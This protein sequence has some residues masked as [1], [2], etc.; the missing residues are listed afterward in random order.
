MRSRWL[1]SP[2]LWIGA[3]G[4]VFLLW[5]WRDSMRAMFMGYSVQGMCM[6]QSATSAVDLQFVSGLNVYP[7]GWDFHYMPLPTW[8]WNPDFYAKIHGRY[9]LNWFQAPQFLVQPEASGPKCTWRLVLPYWLITA[10]Y[11]AGWAGLMGWR[12]RKFPMTKHS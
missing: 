7:T 10:V 8:A 6:F 2:L 11:V 12:I 9:P 5:A 4:L 3:F 1:R